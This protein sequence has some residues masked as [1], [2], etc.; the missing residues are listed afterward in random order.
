MK[1][2]FQD[3]KTSIAEAGGNFVEFSM[4]K[5][6]GDNEFEAIHPPIVCRDF[7]TDLFWY[8]KYGTTIKSES[9]SMTIFGFDAKALKL[10]GI[11]I[12][13]SEFYF[14][15][16]QRVKTFDKKKPS[17]IDIGDKAA[18]IME[19]LNYFEDIL[20]FTN[21]DT[22]ETDD[23]VSVVVQF[24]SNWITY[25]YL[26]SLLTLLV[27]ISVD[28]ERDC[29]P[30]EFLM[31]YKKSGNDHGYIKS[32]KPL[33]E[34]IVQGKLVNVPYQ[35]FKSIGVCHDISGIVGTSDNLS[36]Y[37]ETVSESKKKIRR[38]FVLE[39]E[40]SSLFKKKINPPGTVP[41]PHAG[42][43]L[44]SDVD[45]DSEDDNDEDEEEENDEWTTIPQ[46]QPL[47]D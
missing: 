13:S 25:P 47:M 42:L 28:W 31:N 26:I 34:L 11:S 37:I 38:E 8:S 16:R 30:V 33:L 2:N 32:A 45:H 39:D 9:S 19:F 35:E 22:W 21:S 40:S 12:N 17:Y 23:G 20:G 14:A 46:V 18:A 41:V 3:C 5:V 27:R 29:T 10:S 4:I 24:S 43:T 7:I 44:D 36:K 1:V 15:I 6:S